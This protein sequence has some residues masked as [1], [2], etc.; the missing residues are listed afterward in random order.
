M[1]ITTTRSFPRTILHL[2]PGCHTTPRTW[3]QTTHT[4]RAGISTD[5]RPTHTLRRHTSLSWRAHPTTWSNADTGSHTK[6]EHPMT[7]PT[8]IA[9]LD[10]LYD[11]GVLSEIG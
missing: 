10:G 4:T 11:V 8:A 1:M 9:I 6:G 7:R 2:V 5:A 3:T